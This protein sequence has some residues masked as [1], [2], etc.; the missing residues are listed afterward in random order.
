MIDCSAIFEGLV[1]PAATQLV[2]YPTVQGWLGD[3]RLGIGASEVPK[4]LGLSPYG[5]PWSVWAR[6]CLPFEYSAPTAAQMRGHREEVRI[7][8]DY[9]EFTGHRVEGPLGHVVITGSEPW[10]RQTP[11]AFVFDGETWGQGEVKTDRSDLRVCWGHSGQVFEDWSA[12]EGEVREDYA[13]QL[14]FQL[15][16]TGLPWGLLIVRLSM[17]DL[18]WYRLQR[19]PDVEAWMM[20]RLTAFWALVEGHRAGDRASRPP[21][22]DSEG[23]AAALARM[24]G[25]EAK[26]EV[27]PA[28]PEQATLIAKWH[29]MSTLA[30]KQAA[31]VEQ[32]RNEIAA[33]I[34]E[35]GLYGVETDRWRVLYQRSSSG[36]RFTRFYPRRSS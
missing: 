3:R 25:D 16:C 34:S 21:I 13:A 11:D 30:D 14:Y 4:V 22:D 2:R 17:D 12:A 19:D 35:A 1:L 18:R 28:T 31:R 27:V 7:L 9:A 15:L 26:G 5:G 33:S 10:M 8:E 23:C 6:K 24:V 36:S 20:E 32:L 29:A